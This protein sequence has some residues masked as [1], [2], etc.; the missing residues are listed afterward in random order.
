MWQLVNLMSLVKLHPNLLSDVLSKIVLLIPISSVSK[1][2]VMQRINLVPLRRLDNSRTAIMDTAIRPI[3]EANPAFY[4]H[5]NQILEFE[6]YEFYV[7]Y[8][9]PFF[10][11]ID[12]QTTEIKIESSTPKPV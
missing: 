1:S 7:K 4:V 8:A 6:D 9:R 12:H 5:K 2:E 3:L 11:R 10:G